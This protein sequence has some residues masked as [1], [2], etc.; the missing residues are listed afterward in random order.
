MCDVIASYDAGSFIGNRLCSY[1]PTTGGWGARLERTCP[2]KLMMIIKQLDRRFKVLQL[3]F[4]L[5]NNKIVFDKIVFD[6]TAYKVAHMQG[7]SQ[8]FVFFIIRGEGAIILIYR[9]I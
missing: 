4:S 2:D 5:L 8:E 3:D 7:R 9:K 1:V 6:V